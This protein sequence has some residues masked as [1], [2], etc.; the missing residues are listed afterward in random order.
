MQDGSRGQR[1]NI[2]NIESVF[3][4]N[5]TDSQSKQ[6]VQQSPDRLNSEITNQDT[7]FSIGLAQLP[8]KL[9]QRESI[10]SGMGTPL[11]VKQTQ[12]QRF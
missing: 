2:S 3:E 8:V 9:G 10:M 5:V 7:R 11:E 12:D 1:K 4:K 6:A